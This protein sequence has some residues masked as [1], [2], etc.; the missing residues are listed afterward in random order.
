MKYTHG[1][2]QI[3]CEISLRAQ[4]KKEKKTGD[5]KVDEQQGFCNCG[6]NSLCHTKLKMLLME[7][8]TEPRNIC[9]C[10]VIA[11]SNP[12]FVRALKNIFAATDIHREKPSTHSRT[13]ACAFVHLNA[14]L[15]S[16]KWQAE[17]AEHC[18]EGFIAGMK[19]PPAWSLMK[20]YHK[21]SLFWVKPLPGAISNTA[22]YTTLVGSTVIHRGLPEEETDIFQILIR[23]LLQWTSTGSCINN[24]SPSY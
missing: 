10:I 16:H 5:T 11:L 15:T 14:A 2:S 8:S 6:S 22:I 23:T 7:W 4:K 3:H 17:L 18:L 19:R 13:R 12:V 9:M 1:G 21:P 20:H 24:W